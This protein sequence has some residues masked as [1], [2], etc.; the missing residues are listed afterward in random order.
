MV[1][2]PLPALIGLPGVLVPMGIG[3]TEPPGCPVCAL[4]GLS[5]YRVVG[6][7]LLAA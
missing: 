7:D 3:V 2:A 6:G 1:V 5:A 4:P